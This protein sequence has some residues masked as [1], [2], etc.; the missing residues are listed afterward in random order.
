M[1][2]VLSARWPPCSGRGHVEWP[3]HFPRRARLE[4]RGWGLFCGRGYRTDHASR[5][6][7]AH[8]W[9][10]ECQAEKN[11]LKGGSGGSGEIRTHGCLATSP[12][13]KTGAF[14]RSATLPLG[15]ILAAAPG[16]AAASMPLVSMN[17][18]TSARPVL[19]FRLVITKG[20]STPCVLVRMRRVSASITPRSA[21]T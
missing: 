16:Q 6:P 19:V 14:N 11:R 7:D 17:F 8:R 20:L 10:H 21:P 12:V 18:T 5:C 2:C 15:G 9:L 4:A 3:G 1:R 13:F